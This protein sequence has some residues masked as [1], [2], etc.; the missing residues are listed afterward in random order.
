MGDSE[1]SNVFVVGAGASKEFGLPTGFELKA[2]IKKI[3]DIRFEDGYTQSSG[4][5]E[6]VEALRN[7]ARERSDRNINDYLNA[8]WR[9]RD[10]IDF[11]PSI[12][13]F[14]DTHRDDEYIV[15]FGKLA[16]TFALQQAESQSTLV[17]DENGRVDP[18]NSETW[19][20]RLFSILVAQ[21]TFDDFVAALENITFVSFNYDRCIQHFFVN[22][23]RSYFNSGNEGA[24]R[25]LDALNVVYAYGSIGEYY[26]HQYGS[27]F[28]VISKGQKLVETS[29]L[30]QTFTEGGDSQSRT[31][32]QYA[33]RNADV[34]VYLGFGFLPINMKL[35]AEEAVPNTSR[36]IG[37]AKG[38]SRESAGDV[39]VELSNVFLE[40]ENNFW[41]DLDRVKLIDGTCS[42]LFH[43]FERFFLPTSN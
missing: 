6:V 17:V 37:T 31:A 21:R 15:E 11:A 14:L 34:V 29:R 5:W 41:P 27:S 12:D 36:V 43:E 26:L 40:N 23:A 10:N 24:Q 42:E 9:I 28:G 33:I 32:I 30:I 25:V 19:I 20:G 7:L 13:N 35:L 16:I 39:E 18:R 2:N 38:L 3:C 4:D 1:R 22:V 8:A